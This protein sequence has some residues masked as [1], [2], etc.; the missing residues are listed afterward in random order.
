MLF[1]FVDAVVVFDLSA[2]CRKNTDRLRNIDGRTAADCNQRAAVVLRIEIQSLI[3]NFCCRIRLDFV[4]NQ[5]LDSRVVQNRRHLSGR[6]D[7]DQALVRDDQ[8]LFGTQ[9]AQKVRYHR[10]TV[11]ANQGVS[12]LIKLNHAFVNH[13]FNLRFKRS[14]SLIF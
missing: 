9:A 10:D 13:L 5:I 11:A 1:G 7:L 2:V 3:N 4:K 8:N 6:A 14:F 12:R